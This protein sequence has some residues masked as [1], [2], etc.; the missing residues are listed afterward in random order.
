MPS[1]AYY[2]SSHGYGH[3]ARQQAVI[4]ELAKRGAE[5]HVRSGTN[6]KFFISATSYH[7]QRYDIGMIQHDALHFDIPASLTWMAD[8]L[9]EQPALIAQELAF[10]REKDVQLIVSD[11]PPIAFEIASAAKLPSVAITHFTWD[12]V[13][14]HYIGD[15]PE[16]AYL[17]ETLRESYLKASLALQM[18]V[19]I[20]HPFTMFKNVEALALVHNAT[21]K[22]RQQIREEFAIPDELPMI[23][24][25]MGGHEWGSSDIRALKAYKDAAFLLMPSA[26]EQVKDS[27]AQFRSVPMD[28]PDYHNLIA[29]ADVVVGKAGG[30][31]VAEVLGHQTPMIYTTQQHWRESALLAESLESFGIAQHVPMEDFMKG[32]W[33]DILPSFL[34][35]PQIWPELERNGAQQAAER[36]LAFTNR[37]SL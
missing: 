27:P 26:W 24:L 23:L 29:A 36:L 14:E 33:L 6:P 28:Y 1:I 31:T 4:R 12:W 9:K 32:A 8:F 15:Y 11:M 35:K 37:S 19:P 5:I 7:Q 2:I 17:V 13:Y 30:S 3:A 16:Y 21:T 34:Q 22:S 18:Q 10:V 20:P 25:S